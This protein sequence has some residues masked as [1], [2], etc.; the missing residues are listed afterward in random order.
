MALPGPLFCKEPQQLPAR[1]APGTHRKPKTDLS[2]KRPSSKS[3]CADDGGQYIQRKLGMLTRSQK[4]TSLTMFLPSRPTSF[5][6]HVLHRQPKLSSLGRQR[7]LAED[8]T[9]PR[10]TQLYAGTLEPTKRGSSDSW[11]WGTADFK[12]DIASCVHADSSGGVGLARHPAASCRWQTLE[13]TTSST[14]GRRSSEWETETLLDHS[15]ASELN[16]ASYPCP[17]RK[18][19][20]ARFNIR[21]YEA[22]ARDSFGSIKSLK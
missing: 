7:E 9:S 21:A 2:L 4:T 15:G 16:T 20:P 19:N 3:K 17:F 18:R 8:H 13:N 12:H 11:E 10:V 6:Q 1:T 5:S 14:C 22:C